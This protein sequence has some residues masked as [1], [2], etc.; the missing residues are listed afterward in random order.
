[1]KKKAI[2]AGLA[3]LCVA[4]SA[5]GFAA[6][7]PEEPEVQEGVIYQT[8]VETFWVGVGKAYLSFENSEGEQAF[9]VNVDSGN[10]YEA[11][12]TGEWEMEENGPLTLTATWEE[13][14]NS[15]YLADAVSGEPKEYALEGGVYTIGVQLPSAGVI[16]FTLDPVADKVGEGEPPVPDEP[17]VPCTEHVDEDGDG[18]CDVCG[19]ET[20]VEP[21]APEVQ[22]TLAASTAGG[23]AAE[24]YF[25]DNNTWELAISY[26]TGMAF[27]EAAAGTWALDEAYS[28][29]LTVTEDAGGMLAEDSYIFPVDYTTFEYSG[30]ITVSIPVVGEAVFEFGVQQTEETFTVTFD[31]NDGV[32]AGV[33]VMTSTFIANDGTKKQYVPLSAQP[34]LPEREGYRFAGWDMSK[35]PVL[36]DGV[37]TTEW[38]LGENCSSVYIIPDS[39][40]QPDVMEVTEDMTLYARWV[41]PTEIATEEELRAIG[42]DLGGW[43]VLKN[44]ITLTG[45]WGPVGR[46]YS[47]YEFL[48]ASWWK[49]TFDGVF[50]GDGH[51]IY[52]MELSTLDFDFDTPEDGSADGTTG[53]FGSVCNAE[54]RDVTLASPVID[55]TGTGDASHAYVGVLAAFVQ[56]ERSVFENCKVTD[57]Q[58]FL[59]MDD[60]SYAAISGLLGGHW[61]GHMTGSSASGSIEVVFGYQSGYDVAANHLCVGGL[62]G[63]G[64]AWVEDG[65]SAEADISVKVADARAQAPAET[66]INV[67]VGGLAASGAYT[68]DNAVTGG[69]LKVDC[70][71]AAPD[72]VS[73]FIGGVL[74]TQRYGYLENCTADTSIELI[75]AD[76][77]AGVYRLGRVLGGYDMT[78]AMLF[79]DGTN[80]MKVKDCDAVAVTASVNGKAFAAEIVGEVPSKE[81]IDYQVENGILGML[82]IDLTPYLNADGEYEIFGAE[83]CK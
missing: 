80:N 3:A 63:E 68:R 33:E 23:Q 28:M 27:S 19:E 79:L 55:V 69:S 5:A 6:C 30:T 47:A 13:G 34:V 83:N 62:V 75:R 25:Y 44:D 76:G 22:M 70:S 48:D 71:E 66:V 31:M 10:G 32:S 81:E 78:T 35:S 36:E 9:H 82:G 43:Y 17:D 24:L 7:K 4:C 14:E 64:Y 42:E 20:E 59:E 53:F 41:Q 37:S 49:Y 21:D 65:C 11:W 67:Y 46:Y 57:M 29:V 77:D 12:L 72:T 39:P 54:I 58:V 51:T 50:D 2:M 52:G 18:K 60:V 38:F 15:T 45:E 16:D 26:Y 61:G 8:G 73:A 56:G 40:V 1:M 74:G